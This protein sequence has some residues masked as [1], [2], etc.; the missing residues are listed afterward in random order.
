MD[1]KKLQ[2]IHHPSGDVFV[3]E[4]EVFNFPIRRVYFIKNVPVGGVRGHHA[5]K[6]LKQILICP[7]GAV[8]ITLDNGKGL[9]EKVILDNPDD[10][11][12]VGPYVWRTMKWMEKDSVLLV[13][14]S[15]SFN[16]SDYI[17]QYSDFLEEITLLSEQDRS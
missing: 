17:R 10:A 15:D 8:E 5:H 14:A 7:H 13:L 12:Y 3:F 11:L 2:K 1:I 16:E 6:T 4:S 9:Q